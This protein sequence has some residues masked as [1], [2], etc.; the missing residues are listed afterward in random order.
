[1]TRTTSRCFTVL[2]TALLSL[3]LI[4]CAAKKPEDATAKAETAAKND[5]GPA[6]LGYTI[7]NNKG[8]A[9]YCKQI[10]PTGSNVARTTRCMTAAEWKRTQDNNQRTLEELRRGFDAP[11]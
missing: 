1:M 6:A 11:K 10:R 7:M 5:P 9:M 3:S 8:Q 2:A 4:A